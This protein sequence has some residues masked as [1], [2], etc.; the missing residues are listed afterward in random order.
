[1]HK[2]LETKENQIKK[3]QME[4]NLAKEQFDKQINQLKRD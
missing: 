2:A 1:M 4:S 3:D